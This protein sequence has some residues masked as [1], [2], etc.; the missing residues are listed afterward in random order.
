MQDFNCR[1][2]LG[3]G[4]I[5][6]TDKL[7]EGVWEFSDGTDYD[8]S[9]VPV[10][11]SGSG[12]GSSLGPEAEDCA[13]ADFGEGKVYDMRCEATDQVHGHVCKTKIF[14]GKIP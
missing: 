9:I 6:A 2:W 1:L 4:W 12:S 14:Q 13:Y 11:E 7:I 3:V 5:G 10:L 8:R